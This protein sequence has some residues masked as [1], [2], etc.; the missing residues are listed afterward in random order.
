[1]M[2]TLFMNTVVVTEKNALYVTHNKTKTMTGFDW[3]TGKLIWIA[4]SLHITF[5]TL[6][7]TLIYQQ[8]LMSIT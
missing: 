4:N 6:Y 1:M 3:N 2:D 8:I 7:N 5:H